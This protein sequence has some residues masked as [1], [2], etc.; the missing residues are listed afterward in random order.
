LIV[1]SSQETN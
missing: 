1:F